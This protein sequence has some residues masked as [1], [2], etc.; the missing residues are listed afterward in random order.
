MSEHTAKGPSGPGAP[1]AV[2][3][4]DPVQK[5]SLPPIVILLVAWAA[6]FI[7]LLLNR[8]RLAA[9][10]AEHWVWVCA[11]GV[12][13]GLIGFAVVV[14]RERRGKRTRPAKS[15]LQDRG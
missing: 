14:R 2:A 5:S 13:L 10:G 6:A 8:A 1:P 9:S 11:A 7:V 3:P 15:A 12:G 4:A